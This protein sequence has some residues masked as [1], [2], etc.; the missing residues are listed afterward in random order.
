MIIGSGYSSCAFEDIEGI[1]RTAKV[2]LKDVEFHSFAC[3]GVSG[4]VVAPVLAHAMDKRL[5]VV[6]KA[7]SGCH[8]THFVEGDV[9][10]Y[11]QYVVVDDFLSTGKTIGLI[12]AHITKELGDCYAPTYAGTYLYQDDTF[13]TD[14]S[15]CGDILP[16]GQE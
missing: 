9:N 1:I 4:M 13:T 3:S 6:R 7:L 5:L 16:P 8:A 10:K 11:D 14:W 15:E 12:I 2:K